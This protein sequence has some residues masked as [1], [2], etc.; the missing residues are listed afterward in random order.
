MRTRGR[1]SGK[2]VHGVRLAEQE[3]KMWED[4]TQEAGIGADRYGFFGNR[5]GKNIV[6]MTIISSI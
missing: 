1:L 2:R 6:K 4:S 3:E 5:P